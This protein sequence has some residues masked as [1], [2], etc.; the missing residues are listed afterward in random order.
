MFEYGLQQS[1]R[2]E[3]KFYLCFV[4]YFHFKKKSIDREAL[5]D[6]GDDDSQNIG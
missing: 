4:S 2:S 3:G 6:S 5:C 1:E